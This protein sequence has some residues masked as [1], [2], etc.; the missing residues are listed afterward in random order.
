MK[1]LNYSKLSVTSFQIHSKMEWTLEKPTPIIAYV[2]NTSTNFVI[3]FL[4][5]FHHV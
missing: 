5:W 4:F 3:T 2:N 1:L